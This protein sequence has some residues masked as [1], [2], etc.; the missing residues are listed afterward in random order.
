MIDLLF[1]TLTRTLIL[2]TLLFSATNAAAETVAVRFTLDWKIQGVHAPFYLAQQRGYFADQG[3]DVTID[4]GEGSAATVS[5]VLSGAYDAGFGD[6]N[7]IIQTAAKSPDRA[8]VMVYQ[9]YNQPPFAVLTTADGPTESVADFPG[10]T[11]GGP[12]GSAATKLFPAMLEASDIN[13]DSVSITNVAPQLQEQLLNRGDVDAALVFNVT[14]YMNLV[15]QGRDP[16]ADYRWF[17]YG[18]HGLDIYSNGVMVSQAMIA[19]HPE[20]V[21]GLV[22]AINHA[23]QDIIQDP[24][25]GIAAVKQ[26]EAFIDADAE[27]KRLDYAMTHL[28]VSDE[29]REIGIGDVSTQRL[30]RSIDTIA[31]LYD[32]ESKPLAETVFTDR[33]LPPRDQRL[34]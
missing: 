24:D 34:P 21:E 15:S 30:S 25:A 23:M 20:A 16:Q 9:I 6:M 18:D 27:R 1:R 7:A 19:D 32:L 5:R 13:P 3:L 11:F 17:A 31:D 14:S 26:R 2:G 4:Q 33:F 8:P 12:A 29:S 22:K 10:H 28:I